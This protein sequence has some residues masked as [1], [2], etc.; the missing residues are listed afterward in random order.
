LERLRQID[1]ILAAVYRAAVLEL[2]EAY[3]GT[4]DTEPPL[5]PE[6][7]AELTAELES[8][9]KLNEAEKLAYRLERR[10]ETAAFF[11]R[12]R[13]EEQVCSLK[14]AAKTRIFDEGWPGE[15]PT[16]GLIEEVKA[17]IAEFGI[18]EA[19]IA[20]F[21]TEEAEKLLAFIPEKR[22]ELEALI[23]GSGLDEE[24]DDGDDYQ[25]P[26]PA[27]CEELETL[28]EKVWEAQ[29]TAAETVEAEIEA[30]KLLPY[31]PADIKEETGALCSPYPQDPK[32]ILRRLAGSILMLAREH[33][34]AAA[35]LFKSEAEKLLGLTGAVKVLDTSAAVIP[36]VS[37][38][39]PAAVEELCISLLAGYAGGYPI[40]KGI[41]EDSFPSH[42]LRQLFRA[43]RGLKTSGR[44]IDRGSLAEELLATGEIDA[45]RAEAAAG[46]VL[47]GFPFYAVST[48]ESALLSSEVNILAAALFPAS[49][50]TQTAQD[51]DKAS[52]NADTQ[53]A[54]DTSAAGTVQ[55]TVTAKTLENSSTCLLFDYAQGA[56]IGAGITEDFF[57][58]PW[59]KLY[60]NAIRGIRERGFTVTAACLEA[61]LLK[62]GKL[63]EAE[64][65][66]CAEQLTNPQNASKNTAY[67]ESELLEAYRKTKIAELSAKIPALLAGG[68]AAE[69]ALTWFNQQTDKLTSSSK[70]T[71][72][73]RKISGAE[74][75]N[76]VYPPVDWFVGDLI[77]KGLTVFTG[78]PKIG[79]SWAALQLA[80]AIDQGGYF[81]GRLKAKKTGVL[82]YA[83]EDT[84][85]RLQCRSRKQGTDSYNTAVFATVPDTAAD[86][87]AYLKANPHIQVVIID[88]M[89][90]MLGIEDLNDYS[91]TCRAMASLKA[92]ADE[93]GIAVVVIHHNKKGSKYMPDHLEKGLGS[94]GINGSADTIISLYR[95]R[96][97]KGAALSVS[98]R[99]M[100][101]T[102]YN[103]VWEPALCSWAVTETGEL[104]DMPEKHLRI[105]DIIKGGPLDWK[106]ADIVQASGMSDNEVSRQLKAMEAAGRVEKAGHGLWRA[107]GR[108][109]LDLSIPGDTRAA[110]TPPA[111]KPATVTVPPT[112]EAEPAADTNADTGINTAAAVLDSAPVKA[113]APPREPQDTMDSIPAAVPPAEKGPP[114]SKRTSAPEPVL[115]QTVS[116]AEPAPAAETAKT[117]KIKTIPAPAEAF[118]SKTDTADTQAYEAKPARELPQCAFDSAPGNGG[119]DT[120][121]GALP[122]TV[123]ASADG[124]CGELI[125]LGIDMDISP[126]SVP[127]K[128]LDLGGD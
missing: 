90:K 94:I 98:G 85:A 71:A 47:K 105:L 111:V 81:M 121:G 46:F 95:N 26:G 74:L 45:E 76:T 63:D 66:D 80:A 120:R 124:D 10:K 32:G 1:S 58:N 64:A 44:R 39:P 128:P 49:A 12:A 27:S 34:E 125:D 99:D 84:P 116:M 9:Y 35:L 101:D 117:K 50:D 60:Y 54:Q 23:V 48:L 78:D 5:S 114:K 14:I 75:L 29:E 104:A 19:D 107:A 42:G 52:G 38:Q 31:M 96:G 115:Y 3:S 82:Y 30:G 25:P 118:D 93:L 61:E 21:N 68:A 13:V 103:L 79:K 86:M 20:D 127:P 55:D 24:L 97:E 72:G 2:R 126:E 51:T 16:D 28:A 18:D 102:K 83:L 65:K 92:V 59:R 110:G 40:G 62:S 33:S 88:T 36:P 4:V 41:T 73:K 113:A 57:T 89:Q 91:D 119:E 7:K 37:G 69:E 100:P 106:R 109:E 17:A 6:E 87:Q 22:A 11:L 53:T 67:W 112:A 123:P 43:V 77:T 15:A 8:F 56:E 108:V 70:S 122:A